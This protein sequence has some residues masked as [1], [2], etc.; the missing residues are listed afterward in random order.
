MK[1]RR[2]LECHECKELGYKVQAVFYDD[3]KPH[4]DWHWWK[5][6]TSHYLGWTWE[7]YCYEVESNIK[8]GNVLHITHPPLE[9]M[10][11]DML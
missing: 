11:L 8:S 4:C 6:N 7:E 1:N 2:H 9:A 3:K 10:V 5:L